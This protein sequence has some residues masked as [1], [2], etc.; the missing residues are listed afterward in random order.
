MARRK[1]GLDTP[2]VQSTTRPICWTKTV[3]T[4][5]ARTRTSVLT[6]SAPP[7]GQL[8]C[9]NER[10]EH[11]VRQIGGGNVPCKKEPPR[12]EAFWCPVE[13]LTPALEPPQYGEFA[14]N[15]AST[16]V[17]AR[18][19]RC[20]D[21]GLGDSAFC[22]AFGTLCHLRA[23]MTLRLVSGLFRP[24]YLFFSARVGLGIR[25]GLSGGWHFQLLYVSGGHVIK[26]GRVAPGIKATRCCP[27]RTEQFSRR[28]I[29]QKAAVPSSR[30]WD[31]EFRLSCAVALKARHAFR[32]EPD[33]RRLLAAI[34]ARTA[35]VAVPAPAV[36][37][38]SG[39]AFPSLQAP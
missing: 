16:T 28:F 13:N 4:C 34:A 25:R 3:K 14:V 11:L 6:R 27:G 39:K 24:G 26:I 22:L 17:K 33:A 30:S 32:A 36:W 10:A 1:Q 38:A 2:R 37:A 23:L 35:P 31:G 7:A 15:P 9:K 8:H 29:W 5:F 18:C 20:V 19:F 21:G 12:E